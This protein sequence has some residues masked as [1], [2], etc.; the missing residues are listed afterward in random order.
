MAGPREPLFLARESYRR[1]R[2]GDAAR[3]VPLLGLVL[4]LLPVLWSDSNRTA[5]TIIYIFS[6]WALLIVLVAILSRR[7]VDTVPEDSDAPDD[8]T[9]ER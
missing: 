7:L 2:V 5:D 6:A 4:L 8:Q 1:R 9:A 3:F